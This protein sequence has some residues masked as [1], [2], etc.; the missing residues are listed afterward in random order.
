MRPITLSG[1]AQK[2]LADDDPWATFT[3]ADERIKRVA[4]LRGLGPRKVGR[5]LELGAGNGSNSRCLAGR[6]LRL[7]ATE[8]TQEGQRLVAK[9]LA[10]HQPRA[11]ASRLIVPARPPRTLYDAVVVA[12]LLYYLCPRDME[13]LARQVLS[14]LTPGGVLVLA[15][16]RI[17]FYDF[18]QRAEAIH[19]RFLCATGRAWTIRTMR[20]T[21]KW[22]VLACRLR[23]GRPGAYDGF[24][25][26]QR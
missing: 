23:S 12:E 15:H 6:S 4:I 1:F 5:V 10:G 20:R 24:Y 8:G 11:R 16:H 13:R 25:G 19:N 14:H 17:T 26:E 2:F 21:R 3:D 7:D 9:A 18:A 22:T